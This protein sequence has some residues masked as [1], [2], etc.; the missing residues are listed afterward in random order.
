MSIAILYLL[1]RPRQ[2]VLADP[3]TTE[4]KLCSEYWWATLQRSLNPS[5]MSSVLV[6]KHAPREKIVFIKSKSILQ[7]F[8]KFATF[9]NNKTIEKS[10]GFCLRMLADG[11]WGP[12]GAP[13]GLAGAGAGSR[14]FT[15]GLGLGCGHDQTWSND[16][17]D[18]MMKCCSVFYSLGAMYRATL[19]AGCRCHDPQAFKPLAHLESVIFF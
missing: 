5:S 7:D 16:S 1:L 15:A 17:N 4:L 3:R 6:E 8:F 10:L 14:G 11:G 18:E 2:L 13:L 12:P 9:C 19:E